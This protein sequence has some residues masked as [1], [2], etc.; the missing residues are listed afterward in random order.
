M[1]RPKRG[2]P[3]AM[4]ARDWDQMLTAADAS[5]LSQFDIDSQTGLTLRSPAIVKVRNKTGQPLEKCSIVGLREPVIHPNQNEMEFIRHVAFDA[6]N[7]QI[8]GRFGVLSGPCDVEGIVP[9]VVDGIVACKILVRSEGEPNLFVDAANRYEF[10]S[11]NDQT[12][13]AQVIWRAGGI[14]VQWSLVRIGNTRLPLVL[15]GELIDDM[16]R[17]ALSVG[18]RLLQ[19]PGIA[20]PAVKAV[21][22][23][24]LA[25]DGSDR[26]A[27][28]WDLAV[29]FWVIV[30]VSHKPQYVI[31]SLSLTGSTTGAAS[32]LG[33]SSGGSSGGSGGSGGGGC[34]DL[35]GKRRKIQVVYCE[36]ESPLEEFFLG[37]VGG[38]TG[39]TTTGA[40]ERAAP[41]GGDLMLIEVPV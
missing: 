38:C 18:V 15:T 1:N 5:R 37:K 12:G 2:E 40:G 28:Y 25:G 31:E 9:C 33:G 14:G 39:S 16:P 35:K 13:A 11:V 29:G 3:V 26:V 41:D 20:L 21:N 32:E 36:K 34:Q 6:Y 23:F 24:R 8:F 17:T 19:I 30:Q 22:T 10:L 27:I 7:P 4:A